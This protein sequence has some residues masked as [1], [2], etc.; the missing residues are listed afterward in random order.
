MLDGL[1]FG[2]AAQGERARRRRP[3]GALREQEDEADAHGHG[4]RRREWSCPGGAAGSLFA[5]SAECM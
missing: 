5:S 3:R 4:Q 1:F 2:T